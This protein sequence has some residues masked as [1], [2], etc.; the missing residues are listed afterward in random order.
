MHVK[1]PTQL[2]CQIFPF[3]LNSSHSQTTLEKKKAK[4]IS[5]VLQ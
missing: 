2:M 5:I 3:D 1:N 4:R